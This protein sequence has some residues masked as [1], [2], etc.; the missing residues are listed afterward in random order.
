MA[1][2][3][4]RARLSSAGNSSLIKCYQGILSDNS[5]PDLSSLLQHPFSKSVWKTSTKKQLFIRS[6]L[7]F[8]DDCEDYLMSDC[9]V[10]LGRPFK[11]WSVTIIGDP[12][13]TRLNLFRIRLLAGCAGLEQDA[14]RFRHRN[15]DACIQGDPT[16]KLCGAAT[17]DAI[18]FIATCPALLEHR[19][20]VLAT[21]PK[22]V[23]VN[24]PDCA[25]DPIQFAH[26][27][28][29]LGVDWIDHH[30]TQMFCINLLHQLRSF[31]LSLL[32]L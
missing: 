12:K 19:L 24:I 11:Q 1:K 13:A 10:K 31:S 29:D 28:L 23:K 20:S 15:R 2:Q 8:L 3:I 18:H 16:C 30:P 5:L 6:F 17:E 14:S 25:T 21:A 32:E 22:S 7:H 4:L 27:M 26:M 9:D